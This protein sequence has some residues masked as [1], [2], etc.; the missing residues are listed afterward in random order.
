MT[1]W[2][3]V[4]YDGAKIV[5]TET[6]ELDVVEVEKL[7][8][9]LLCMSLT[10]REIIGATTGEYDLLRVNSSPKSRHPHPGSSFHTGGNPFFTAVEI[11]PEEREEN[12]SRSQ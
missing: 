12:V 11:P 7:L 8:R 9:R 10:P 2:R 1:K 6:A 3:I 5:F 4:G